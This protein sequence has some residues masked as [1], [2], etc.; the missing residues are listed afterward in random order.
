LAPLLFLF[1][2]ALYAQPPLPS[3]QIER[4]INTVRDLEAWA[5]Q[6]DEDVLDAYTDA[7]AEGMPDLEAIYRNLARSE[8]EVRTIIQ[9]HGFDDG[10]QWANVGSRIAQAFMAL[11]MGDMQA[12][13]EESIAETIREIEQSPHLSDE[14]KSML[15][16]QMRSAQGHMQTQIEQASEEDMRAVS[17]KRRELRRLFEFDEYD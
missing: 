10:D 2:G 13:Y 1:A 12:E 16:E 15:M 17:Q 9:R 7:E 11:E 14:Q 3:D 4:W 8:S 5:A 6:V